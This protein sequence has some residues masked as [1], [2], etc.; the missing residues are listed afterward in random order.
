M[1]LG[2]AGPSAAQTESAE[3]DGV[4]KRE[5]KLFMDAWLQ[6]RPTLQLRPRME[7][8][9]QR[10]LEFSQA[11]TMRTQIGYGTAR[12]HGFSIYGEMENVAAICS[13]C[14]RDPTEPPNGMTVIADPPGT[15]VNQAF[16]R[17]QKEEWAELDVVGGRQTIVL[18]DS[19][20]VG[21]VDWRQNEQTYDGGRIDSSLGLDGL[22]AMYTYVSSVRRIFGNQGSGGTKNF[23]SNTHFIHATYSELSFT[24]ATAFVYLMDLRRPNIDDEG[25]N[26]NAT[27]GVR[28]NGRNE[29]NDT[30]AIAHQ[31]SYAYQM[32]Y[33]DQPIEYG[34]HYA[35][36]DLRLDVKKLGG[37][38][39]AFELLGSDDGKQRILTPLSTAHKFNGWADVFLDNG[40]PDG[41]RDMYIYI[42]P[43]L[44]WGMKSRF[45]YH[46]FWHDNGG[47]SLGDEIDGQIKKMI[48][49]KIAA[50]LKGAYFIGTPDSGRQD[51][52]R[53]WL[54]LDFKF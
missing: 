19:R 11:Y 30:F 36:V 21:N 14:Y 29:L 4:W 22:D 13:S 50:L 41:L 39:A 54:E 6:G 34:A 31:L 20:W 32:N 7:L 17:F 43:K 1:A 37:L 49:P 9:K 25:A 44:P 53:V 38:G 45:A 23:K 26:S 35:M 52:W 10:D 12:Y 27:F 51:I 33:A 18:D 24:K 16:A 46:H 2:V 42:Q 15:E 8:A 40:G 48:H 3:K 5:F 28:F 47:L